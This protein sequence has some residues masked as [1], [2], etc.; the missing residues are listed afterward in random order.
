LAAIY[1]KVN[2]SHFLSQSQ[3]GNGKKHG[4]EKSEKRRQ[5]AAI[6]LWRAKVPLS[7]IRK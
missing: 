4:R 2:L 7:N 6:E 3:E 5:R 1:I